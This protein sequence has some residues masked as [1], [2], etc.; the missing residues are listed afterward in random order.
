[1]IPLLPV[2]VS[3]AMLTELWQ[4]KVTESK[5]E[6]DANALSHI[7][8]TVLGTAKVIRLV[9]DLKAEAPIVCNLESESK[10]TACIPELANALFPIDTRLLP[11]SK[12]M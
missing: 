6:H 10:L 8:I 2:N 11:C 12:N 1:M 7:I 9:Q 5:D 3:L 4:L